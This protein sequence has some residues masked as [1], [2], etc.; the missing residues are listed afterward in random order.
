MFLQ[1]PWEVDVEFDLHFANVEIEASR[2]ISTSA[3]SP[4]YW[5]F[6]LVLGSRQSTPEPPASL[7]QDAEETLD[8][9]LAGLQLLSLF[10]AEAM[11][12][13]AFWKR[14]WWMLNPKECL[15]HWVASQ[16]L[17]HKWIATWTDFINQQSS[18]HRPLLENILN[19]LMNRFSV[20]TG[21]RTMIFEKII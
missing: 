2:Y 21:W 19:C 8:F 10:C 9:L 11:A 12:M 13:G 6:E 16:F 18:S 3:G 1:Q 4:S 7:G 5:V 15:S 14:W 17:I 20:K